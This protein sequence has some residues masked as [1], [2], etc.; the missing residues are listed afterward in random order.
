MSCSKHD[1]K[2]E[3][4]KVQTKTLQRIIKETLNILTIWQITLKQIKLIINIDKY[5]HCRNIIL[6]G[7]GKKALL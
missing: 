7:N 4:F 2:C 3:T 6:E 1:N 5:F